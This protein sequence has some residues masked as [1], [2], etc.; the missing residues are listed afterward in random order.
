MV[1]CQEC[2]EEVGDALI[3]N[4]CGSRIKQPNNGLTKRFCAHCG[5]EMGVSDIV[6]PKCGKSENDL[7]SSRIGNTLG[8]NLIATFNPGT[9]FLLSLFIVGAGHIYLGLFKRG[10]SFLITQIVLALILFGVLNLILGLILGVIG[11][12]IAIIIGSIVCFVWYIISI[13][14]VYKAI[15]MIINGENVADDI[16]FN[17]LMN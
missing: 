13:Y 17:K 9:G 4:V 7:D 1:K 3:C 11:S 8:N 10:I 12:L 5:A 15:K 2:G 14:D 16:A 6:C